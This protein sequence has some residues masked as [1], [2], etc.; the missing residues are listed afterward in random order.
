A[1]ERDGQAWVARGDRLLD[2]RLP[3]LYVVHSSGPRP[4]G[5]GASRPAGRRGPRPGPRHRI[6]PATAR[7][8][9]PP[10]GTLAMGAP[11]GAGRDSGDSGPGRS[12]RIPWIV[13]CSPDGVNTAQRMTPFAGAMRPTWHA[14][15]SALGP[16]PGP[17]GKQAGGPPNGP[18]GE[19]IGPV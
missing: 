8:R 14:A 11:P 10:R 3:V 17:L 18:P 6:R 5:V 1:V 12:R 13:A 19:P 15:R 4:V 9:P 16:P 7:R 2:R